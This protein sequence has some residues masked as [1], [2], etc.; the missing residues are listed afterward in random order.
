MAKEI[1]KREFYLDSNPFEKRL[2]VLEGGRL[3]E[4]Y[5]EH[6]GDKGITGNIYKGKVV[7]VLPGMQAAFVEA[8]LDR[9][10]FLHVSDVID[11][12]E[13]AK[14]ASS[15]ND[16]DDND[17][18]DDSERS[19]DR[20]RGRGRGRGGR[21]QGQDR[22]ANQPRIQDI[23]KEGQEIIV[24]VEKEPIG[25]KGARVT[26]Y[27]SIPGRY[28][29]FMPAS[30]RIGVSRRISN[31]R[32]RRRLKT[33]VSKARKPE[34]GFII[35]TVCE[36]QDEE[37]LIADMHF[38]VKLWDSIGAG[39]EKK[40]PPA[41]LYEELDLTLRSIR[42]MVTKDVERFVIGSK[43]EYDRVK[44]FVEE[45]M[46]RV[47]PK[48]ELYDGDSSIFDV[49]GVDIE[50]EKALSKTVWLPSGGHIVIDQMEALTAI[51]INTGKYVGRKNS[52]QTIFKTNIESVKEVVNQLRLRNIG[53]II[54]IDFIDMNK[55]A[56]REKVYKTLKDTLRQDKAKT[57]ILKISELGI[58]EMTRKRTRESIT[59]I[60]SEQCSNCEGSGLVKSKQTIVM[61]VFK[62]L[63]RE[64]SS[65]SRK[66]TLYANPAIVEKMRE[67]EGTLEWLERKFGKRIVLKSV[68][69]YHQEEYEII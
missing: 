67:R 4:F 18:N 63:L 19:N 6:P 28:L 52:E 17:S 55:I 45:F 46:P 23:L 29:V 68:E 62:D 36:G 21:S 51:D 56:N 10:V 24:Q 57:N 13:V 20:G 64:L 1:I 30:P 35:R 47:S 32:E 11:A 15:D 49:Y 48:I 34:H 33:I 8:G 50:V 25:T 65:K 58:V 38:L 69:V 12:R 26:A 54:V 9:T 60:L 14:A 7:R 5:V 31:D 22:D 3:T 37:E 39:V 42:D 2:A 40:A 27:L 43:E 53:G 16:G 44:A 59:Q 41:L 66:F 61:E